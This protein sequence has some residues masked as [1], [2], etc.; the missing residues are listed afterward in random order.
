MQIVVINAE[1]DGYYEALIDIL[2]KYVF[3]CIDGF[4]TS[5]G[6]CAYLS[7]HTK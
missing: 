2:S 1:G 7:F 6:I 3:E 4:N 5:T